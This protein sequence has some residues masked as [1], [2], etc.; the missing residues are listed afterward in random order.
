MLHHNCMG[1]GNVEHGVRNG[2]PELLL[3]LMNESSDTTE[4]VTKI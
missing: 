4:T 3:L 1:K 2:D